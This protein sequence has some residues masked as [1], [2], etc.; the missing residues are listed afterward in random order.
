MICYCDSSF[1]LP[2][3][4]T[5]YLQD[6][7][8]EIA[9]EIESALAYVPLTILTRMEVI[10]ALRFEA[11]LHKHDRTKGMPP[12]RVNDSLNLF[13]AE[14]GGLFQI[15]EA[16]WNKVFARAEALSRST[17]DKGWRTMDILHV[18]TAVISGAKTFYSFDR[19]Q[20]ELARS[21]GMATPLI[22]FAGG[23]SP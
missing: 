17:Q 4:Y 20:N 15:V 18:A 19:Q 16:D 5:S 23:I 21:E 9:G 6:S 14:L 8:A 10:Q 12:T 3:L 11:W 13:F 22:H 7:A 1:F 2:Q